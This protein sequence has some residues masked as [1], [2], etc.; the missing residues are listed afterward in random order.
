VKTEESSQTVLKGILPLAVLARG[1][2]DRSV[3]EHIINELNQP[4]V[5]KRADLLTW[6]Y[7]LAGLVVEEE[8][9][10]LWLKQR[11]AMLKN[12][13]EESW[14]Y[15]EIKK[16]GFEEGLKEACG[17]IVQRQRQNLLLLIQ[18]YFP[19]LLQ[20][21]EGICNAIQTFEELQDLLQ[22]VLLAK[23]DEQEV[24]QHL[25]SVKK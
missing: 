15:Q 21:A 5:E 24:R 18:V 9:D 23:K 22:K 7:C 11:F 4:E 2:Q 16:E 13:L 10:R 1:G 19:A 3:I 12:I 8:S 14:T 6:T 25:L 17:Q 20:L